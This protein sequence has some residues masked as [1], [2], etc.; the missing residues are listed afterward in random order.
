[1]IAHKLKWC[2]TPNQRSVCS[3]ILS[4]ICSFSLLLFKTTFVV[5]DLSTKE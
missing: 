3:W 5:L 1:H 2:Q 4:S